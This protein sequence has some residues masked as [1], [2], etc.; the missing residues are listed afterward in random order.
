MKTLV[1][2]MSQKS[3]R[4]SVLSQLSDDNNNTTT[5][6]PIIKSES[7]KENSNMSLNGLSSVQ[8]S[9]HSAFPERV[10]I[11]SARVKFSTHIQ[12]QLRTL[13]T[14]AQHELQALL[15]SGATGLFL[16]TSFVERNNLN[17]RKL[18]RAI[19][20]GN[21]NPKDKVTPT[22]L[23]YLYEYSGD[24]ERVRGMTQ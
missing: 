16:S 18:P 23:K 8:T 1:K 19:C 2:D 4:F 11:R 15:D 13:D 5:S 22:S 17:T 7:L 9:V 12:V 14:G 3:N 10:H 24:E 6:Q 20:Q 21:S